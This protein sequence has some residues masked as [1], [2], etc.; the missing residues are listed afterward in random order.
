MKDRQLD[1][2]LDRKPAVGSGVVPT[3]PQPRTGGGSLD[4]G[5]FGARGIPSTY[6]GYETFLTV[7]L[8]DLAARGHR[9]TMYCRAGEVESSGSY[10]GVRRVVL[11]SVASKQLSTL[12]PRLRRRG[13]D[14][15]RP[16]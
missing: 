13:A 14:R 10:R 9:V 8:P 2:R 6:S 11:P 12:T 15:G 5:V 1:M 3:A 16:P 7:L 4:I